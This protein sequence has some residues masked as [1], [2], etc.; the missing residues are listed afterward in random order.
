MLLPK[1]IANS[2]KMVVTISF[3][4]YLFQGIKWD[5]P[6][7]ELTLTAIKAADKQEGNEVLSFVSPP[8]IS[9]LS[10]IYC[11]SGLICQSR[12]DAPLL[13]RHFCDQSA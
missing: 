3:R 9:S 5:D 13:T 4:A 1:I 2:S 7:Y 11:K 6:N 8:T 10:S 12:T